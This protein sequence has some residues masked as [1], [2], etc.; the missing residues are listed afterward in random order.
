M[1]DEKRED[2][3]GIPGLSK[4]PVVGGLFGSKGKQVKKTELIIF[5][6]PHIILGDAMVAGTEP[7]KLVPTDIM[8]EHIRE[9]FISENMLKIVPN[10]KPKLQE[11][12]QKRSKDAPELKSSVLDNKSLIISPAGEFGDKLKDLKEF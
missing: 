4:I 10:A 11:P 6:T 8:P 12:L 2:V 3:S 1:K 5:I 7:Q 9:K